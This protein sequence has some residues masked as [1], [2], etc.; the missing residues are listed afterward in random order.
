MF[1]ELYNKSSTV[2]QKVF[3]LKTSTCEE[4]TNVLSIK[5]SS[6]NNKTISLF[7]S[8]SQLNKRNGISALL[9]FLS[10]KYHE[11]FS[12][13]VFQKKT[14]SFVYSYSSHDAKWSTLLW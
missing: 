7:M 11:N 4:K 9:S 3:V 2:L 10:N 13:L 14:F 5:V 6:I 8:K 1:K 12:K